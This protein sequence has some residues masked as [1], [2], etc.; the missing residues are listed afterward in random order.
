MTVMNET[1]IPRLKSIFMFAPYER[2]SYWYTYELL[3]VLTEEAKTRNVRISLVTSTNLPA[4]YRDADYPISCILP[5]LIHRDQHGSPLEWALSRIIYFTSRERRFMRWIEKQHPPDG[6]HFQ[7]YTPW[8]AP[9]HFKRLRARGKALFFTVH[10][11]LP[12]EY[13]PLIPKSLFDFLTRLGLRQCNALFTHTEYLKS[14]LSQFL[15][16]GHPPIVVTPLGVRTPPGNR[17]DSENPSQ[18]LR[19]MSILFFGAIR[20]NKGLPVLVRAMQ[21]LPDFALTIA[22]EPSS[23]SMREEAARLVATLPLDRVRFLSRHIEE[24]EIPELF[25][26]SSALVLPYTSLSS[27]SGV[28][29]LAVTHSTPVVVSDVAGMGQEVRSWGIGEVVAPNDDKSL[30]KAIRDLHQPAR[31]LGAFEAIRALRRGLSWEPGA[32]IAIDTYLSTIRGA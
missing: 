10:N 20:S 11:V 17:P 32:K 4:R 24:D 30:V 5:L 29:H 15:G 26:S 16:T 3:S 1:G 8:M 19:L 2:A 22:G 12:H 25:A 14:Q 21:D 9:I 28:L 31:Y 18:R 27:Q 7:V 23:P 6:I 13:P